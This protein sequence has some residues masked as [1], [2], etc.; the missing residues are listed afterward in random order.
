MA[1]HEIGIVLD[2]GAA[3]GTYA[4][5]LR[6]A[7]YGGRIVSFEPVASAFAQLS[8]VAD[9]DQA[10]RVHR[11]AL[12]TEA[13]ELQINVGSNTS[14]SSFLD[15]TEANVGLVDGMHMIGREW[16]SV[17]RLDA[18]GLE[19]DAPAM[20]KLDVQGLE[21]QVLEGAAAILDRIELVEI[22]LSLAQLYVGQPHALELANWLRDRGFDLVAI[23]PGQVDP[24][25]GYTYEIDGIFA[26]R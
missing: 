20:A 8:A 25:S 4:R 24:V 18:L 22:E 9:G 15:L 6:E 23:D 3:L 14:F 10:W 13:S 11:L 12:G 2:V 16:V 26:R 17:R 21:L 7:G 19:L 5:R 1:H